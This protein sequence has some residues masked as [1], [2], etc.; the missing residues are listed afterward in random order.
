MR[1]LIVVFG[2]TLVGCAPLYPAQ[3]EPEGNGAT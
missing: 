3:I 1:V 2:V